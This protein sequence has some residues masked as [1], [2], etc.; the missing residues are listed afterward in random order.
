MAVLLLLPARRLGAFPEA[1][2]VVSGL[3]DV[4][5]VGQAV[6][7][8]GGHLCVAEDRRPFAEAEIG[9][10]DDAGALIELAQE[11]KSKAP[12]VALNGR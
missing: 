7:E 10:D 1:E 8:R 11:W 2:A 4:A 6:E 3:K 5:A 12:P 9:S